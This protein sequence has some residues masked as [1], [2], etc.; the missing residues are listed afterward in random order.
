MAKINY[1]TYIDSDYTWTTL[2]GALNMN[3]Y[4]KDNLHL[5]EKGNEKLVKAIITAFNVGS[6]KQQQPKHYY[7]THQSELWREYQ[8][9]NQQDLQKHHQDKQEHEKLQQVG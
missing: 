5:I 9:E 4:S 2:G 6:L 1:V 8:Q 3:L 7:K